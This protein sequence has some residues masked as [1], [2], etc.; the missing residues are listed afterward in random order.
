MLR[1]LSVYH[2]RVRHVYCKLSGVLHACVVDS[3]CVL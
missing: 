1:V 3:G 2:K